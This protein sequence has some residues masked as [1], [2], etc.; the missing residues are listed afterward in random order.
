[1]RSLTLTKID[2]SDWK[3]RGSPLVCICV[4]TYNAADTVGETLKSI[5]AQTYPNLVVHVSD[6]A[7]TDG[8]LSV[9]ESIADSRIT[10]HRYAENIGGEGNFNRCI[11]LAE[12]EYTALFHADDVYEPDIVAKQVAF[13][14]AN[15]EAGAVFTE[16]SLID[17]TGNS[18][19]V[20]RL[21][22][23]IEAQRGLYDFRA[24]FKAVLRHSN[25]FI[26]PSVMVRTK[27]YQQEI[28]YWRGE[29]FKS[30]ADLDLW[31][32]ILQRHLIGYLPEPLLRYRISHNQGSA[33]VRLGTVRADFFLVI[34]H[35][36]AQ[37]YVQV[38]LNED[39]LRNYRWLERRDRV[40][41]AINLY[42]MDFPQ[43]ASSLLQDVCSWDAFEAALKTKRGFF[44]LLLGAYVRL[45]TFMGMYK[46]G[47]TSLIFMKR[48]SRK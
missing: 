29:L 20:L 15:P 10:I 38:L 9:I 42:I 30:S 28:K 23:D 14:D 43:Q 33:R 16:A 17:E 31:L 25:F 24:M 21:P 47:K 36:L 45:L 7:S 35:Y 44:V 26:C 2:N 18:I 34:D 12:G 37:E 19:G 3:T 32:R 48:L 39:D 6:N 13:L 41:R 46:F 27:V 4:P 5:L 1:L 22:K 8:T 11:Q 40:M